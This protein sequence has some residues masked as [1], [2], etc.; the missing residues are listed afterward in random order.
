[1]KKTSV[2]ALFIKKALT[3]LE[4]EAHRCR[5]RVSAADLGLHCLQRGNCW[6]NS[7]FVQIDNFKLMVS[8]ETFNLIA[9][10]APA[11]KPLCDHK[12]T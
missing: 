10:K 8:V 5:F 2:S 6:L 11:C 7:F 9:C 4:V 3:K 1:M 12:L